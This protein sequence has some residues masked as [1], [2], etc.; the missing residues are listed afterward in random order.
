[1][2]R[3]VLSV[4]YL[5]LCVASS[6]ASGSVVVKK[7]A[8]SSKV[9]FVFFAGLE[10]SGHHGI[11]S[12]YKKCGVMCAI[13]NAVTQELYAG[14]ST[15][16]GAFVY[17]D[18]TDKQI[19][20]RRAAAIDAFRRVEAEHGSGP[21]RLVFVN[22]GAG[23]D[24]LQNKSGEMSYPNYA[25][26]NKVLHSPDVTVLARLAEDAGVD[27]RVVVLRR[28]AEDILRSTTMHRHFGSEAHE[29]AVLAESAAYLAA[30]LRMLD[31]AFVECVTIDA[32]FRDGVRALDALLWGG[33]EFPRGAE[34]GG[35]SRRLLLKSEVERRNDIDPDSVFVDHLGAYIAGIDD[36]CESAARR[37]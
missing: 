31:P 37:A 34:V 30:Q 12:A 32:L 33:A 22:G 10:G 23:L 29:A 8:V 36:A 15:P 1:M 27:L 17:G 26:P 19:R 16:H 4:L 21:A 20:A 35:K 14:G 24:K 13:A 3:L 18:Q 25:G 6:L 5:C 28:G 11:N 2:R 7:D 9:R